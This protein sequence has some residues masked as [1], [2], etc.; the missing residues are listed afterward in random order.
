MVLFQSVRFHAVQPQAILH[1]LAPEE[2]SSMS[3]SHAMLEA[4]ANRSMESA[5]YKNRKLA[6]IF[7]MSIINI[8]I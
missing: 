7:T 3:S 6:I 5:Q 8:G 4:A 2:C 1:R